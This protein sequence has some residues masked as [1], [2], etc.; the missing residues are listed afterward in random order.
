MN[1]PEGW[2]DRTAGR[3]EPS[4]FRDAPALSFQRL[5]GDIKVDV[6]IVGG[7]I[8]GM[9]CAYLLCKEG[10]KVAVID[11][12]NVGSGETGRT[13]AHITCALDDRYYSLEK[14]HG[15]EGARLAASSHSAAIDVVESIVQKEKIGCSF[16]RLDGFLFL[17][18]T[19]SQESLKKEL[20]A[21]R[22]A[23]IPAELAEKAPLDFDTGPCIK[24]PRQAQF[25]PLKYLAGVARAVVQKGGM[26]FTQT[27]ADRIKPSGVATSGGFVAAEKIIVATNAPIVDRTSKV[28]DRQAA[29]RTYVIAAQVKKGAVTKALYWDTGDHRSKNAVPPYHYV[30]LQEL[31]GK[32]DL[33]VVGGE[34]HM[35]GYAN[36][37]GE[38]YLRLESWTRER[39]PVEKIHYRW[40]GQVLEPLDGLAFIGRNPGD[41]DNIFIATGDSGNGITHGTVAGMLL[42]DLVLG[43]K[44]EWAGLYDP[45]RKPVDP[46]KGEGVQQGQSEKKDR[47]HIGKMLEGMHTG[48]GTVIE[49]SKGKPIA[50]YKGQNGALHTYS[51]V[52]PHLGCMVAWNEAEKS[53]DCPCH[54][55]R[56]SYAGRA[57]NGPAN[58]G[59]AEL[60]DKGKANDKAK[61]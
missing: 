45:A 11:D 58:D 20:D 39:F 51:A 17:D 49:Q 54:G 12:G 28:Y 52:C 50:A 34:D 59:L 56:F 36:D 38:R 19:D 33:L 16:E 37:A 48:S 9:T 47:V 61:H 35:T 21:A 43:R 55:S 44:N 3:T 2:E 23:G 31:D 57:V 5:E 41:R 22:R 60:D 15:E 42:V 18:P 1:A 27:H 14:K 8:A 6:A 7:G 10:K 24:F 30:R 40:S 46:Y 53:F 26:V 13:T 29:Y 32:Y 25:Q 4:W